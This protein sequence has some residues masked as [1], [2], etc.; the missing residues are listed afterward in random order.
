ML[1]YETSNK[2]W[3]LQMK[4]LLFQNGFGYAWESQ[5]RIFMNTEDTQLF[6]TKFKR[7]L[8][9]IEDSRPVGRNKLRTFRQFKIVYGLVNYLPAIENFQHSH[10]GD[11]KPGSCANI[12]ARL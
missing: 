7:R 10:R 8:E 2:G 9:D 3:S 1:A 5:D 6:Q 12:L 11:Q 4:T